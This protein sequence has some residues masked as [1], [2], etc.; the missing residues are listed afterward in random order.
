MMV[1]YEDVVRENVE[2]LRQFEKLLKM[3][4]QWF[5]FQPEH[6]D[7]LT[8]KQARNVVFDEIKELNDR[9]LKPLIQEALVESSDELRAEDKEGDL[10]VARAKARNLVASVIT[11]SGVVPNAYRR[12]VFHGL[13]ALNYG[14]VQTFMQPKSTG[15]WH[16]PYT[17]RICRCF[18]VLHVNFLHGIG[19]KKAAA[20]EQIAAKFSVSESALRKWEQIESFELFDDGKDAIEHAKNLGKHMKSG[21]SITDI[22]QCDPNAYDLLYIAEPAELE[23]H[24]KLYNWSRK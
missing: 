12:E 13:R 2:L 14:E 8:L 5:Y 17:T 9:F 15:Q 4:L 16:R 7:D 11:R 1:F 18:A 21:L 19:E 22:R 20:R 6:R 3:R 24:A 23:E 10:E